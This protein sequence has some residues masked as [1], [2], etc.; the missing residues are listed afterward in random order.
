MTSHAIKPR[1]A[2]SR[3]R[4]HGLRHGAPP[5]RRRVP[6]DGLQPQSA[7]KAAPLVGRRGQ[8]S[9]RRPREAA[10]GAD[11]VVSMVADDTA[12]RGVWLGE[13]GALGRRVAEDAVLIESQHADGRLGR[14]SWPRRRTQSGCELL[15]APV[16]GSKT[17]AAAGELNFLVGGSAAAWKGRGPCSPRWARASCTLG[18]TGSGALLKLI[19][20]F[21]CGVQAVSL[22]E[23]MALIERS[24]L[25]RGQALEVLRQ[26]R[27]GQSARQGHLRRA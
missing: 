11:V 18:P 4:P 16:T 12:S 10:A 19:N 1:V 6:A 20:N 8:S 9:R 5:P 13:N 21:L 17:Q 3:P 7:D 23:A 26:R 27:A 25:D 15:D 14:A 2:I 24:G 22:A